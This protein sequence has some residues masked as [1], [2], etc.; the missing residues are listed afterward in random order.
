MMNI[1]NQL[2]VAGK[3]TNGANSAY[4]GRLM[5]T[6]GSGSWGHSGKITGITNSTGGLGRVYRM[7]NGPGNTMF[8][9][10]DFVSITTAAQGTVAC[11]GVAQYNYSTFT[12][13]SIGSNFASG[14]IVYD[15]TYDAT[16]NCV[17]MCGKFTR[18]SAPFLSSFAKYDIGT[19]TWSGLGASGAN[20]N[21]W[22]FLL[23]KGDKL[24]L[25]GS[26]STA[27]GIS[28]PSHLLEVTFPAMTFRALPG[29]FGGT[30]SCGEIHPVTGELYLGAESDDPFY[31]GFGGLYRHDLLTNPVLLG[32]GLSHSSG[33]N[34]RKV[35]SLTWD[36]AP[37][38][39]LYITGRFT[40][41]GAGVSGASLTG[42]GGLVRFDGFN[43]Y[44]FIPS[45][46]TSAKL[47]G[48]LDIGYAIYMRSGT[49]NKGTYYNPLGCSVGGSFDSI[50]PKSAAQTQVI[51]HFYGVSS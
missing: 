35:Y 19:A 16:N 47:V 20:N 48:A 6:Q 39:R 28:V 14:D 5:W 29:S 41:T 7:C 8:L 45:T 30:W 37:N 4:T 36:W 50:S 3:Y 12:V 24:Y 43:W 22:R 51:G 27:H 38:P 44:N 17:Y 34:Y 31:N 46:P 23:R 32:N 10:G 1:S 2:W 25:G 49:E 18:P 21:G 13:A 11:V 15:G 40:A 26:P 42:L 33:V 9:F